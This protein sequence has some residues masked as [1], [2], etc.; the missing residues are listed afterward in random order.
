MISVAIVDDDINILKGLKL[1]CEQ[2]EKENNVK[3]YI[4]CFS[5][6]LDFLDVNKKFDLVFMDIIMPAYDGMT[7]SKKLREVNEDIALIFVT[8]SV[9]YAVEGYSVDASCYI[10]KPIRYSQFSSALKKII[11]KLENDEGNNKI[12]FIKTTDGEQ[13]I[14]FT[15]IEYIEICEHLLS[16]HMVNNEEKKAWLTLKDVAKLIPSDQFGRC[17]YSIIANFKYVSSV[18]KDYI[19]MKNG[20][21]LKLSRSYKK[22]FLDNFYRWIGK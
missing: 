7:A 9:Q 12:L 11:R 20:T 18:V 5:N 6:A 21:K 1:A 2:F 16:I 10:L 17:N 14:K 4:Q 22:D 13:F 8:S 19:I 15:E 3:F